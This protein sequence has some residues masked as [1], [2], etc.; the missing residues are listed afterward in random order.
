MKL[1]SRSQYGKLYKT[2]DRI[3]REL[4][5]RGA[6]WA[7]TSAQM[8]DQE[9]RDHLEQQGRGGQPPPLSDMTRRIYDIDGDPDGSGIVNHLTLEY[10]KRGNNFVAILGI[11][12]G[13]P[14]M[15]AKVQDRGQIIEVTDKMRG[16]LAAAYGIYLKSTTTHIHIPARHFW[17]NSLATTNAAARRQLLK[18]FKDLMP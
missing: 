14:T 13:K 6:Q 10:Q 4:P 3:Q 18:L 9:C 15:I 17:E 16:F 2:L 7:A 11:P 8:M 12:Q 1:K 5:R